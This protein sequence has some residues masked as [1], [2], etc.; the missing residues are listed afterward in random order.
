[1]TL[2]KQQQVAVQTT[3]RSVETDFDRFAL[4][5]Y[6]HLFEQDQS[7][8]KLF[9]TDLKQQG[10]VLVRMLNIALAGLDR[11]ADLLPT[12]HDMGRHHTGY[13]VKPQDFETFGK[14]LTQTLSEFLG[15]DFTPEVAEAWNEFY[16]ILAAAAIDGMHQ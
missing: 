7:L 11:P 15:S 9:K 10:D 13:G 6:G 3:F 8:R 4:A 12:L 5:F 16:K 2:S 1:M 14:A